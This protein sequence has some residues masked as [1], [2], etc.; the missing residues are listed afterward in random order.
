VLNESEVPANTRLLHE[1]LVDS[2]LYG[3]SE[4]YSNFSTYLK[5]TLLI[6][7]VS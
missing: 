6:L 7:R 3:F 5:I 2:V 1:E 4:F